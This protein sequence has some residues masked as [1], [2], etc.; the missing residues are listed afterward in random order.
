MNYWIFLI[1][2]ACSFQSNRLDRRIKMLRKLEGD[3][4]TILDHYVYLASMEIGAEDEC[5]N[6]EAGVW[7]GIIRGGTYI[8]NAALRIAKECGDDL[9]EEEIEIVLDSAGVI[10]SEDENDELSIEYFDSDD[11]LNEKWDELLSENASFDLP[12]MEVE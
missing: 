10:L 9:N 3:D 7:H 6:S 12:D 4:Q 8:A 11:E 5:G 1:P 2:I